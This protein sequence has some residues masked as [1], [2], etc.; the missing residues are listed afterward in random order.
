MQYFGLTPMIAQKNF[1]MQQMP[2][3]E[4]PKIQ[5]KPQVSK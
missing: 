3:P 4:P 1:M 2:P 5:P